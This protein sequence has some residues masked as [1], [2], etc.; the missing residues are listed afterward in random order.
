[1]TCTI[2]ILTPN[3]IPVYNNIQTIPE[4]FLAFANEVYA[5][6][7]DL[8][9]NELEQLN[10]TEIPWI[11]ARKGLKPWQ[12]CRNIIKEDDM[13]KYYRTLIEDEE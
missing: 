5:S 7:G 8:D 2:Y 10:H 9:G 13:K 4:E 11:N 6:Y 3:Y 1:M 12:G